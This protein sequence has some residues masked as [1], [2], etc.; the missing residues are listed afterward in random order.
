MKGAVAEAD[1][2]SIACVRRIQPRQSKRPEN[3]GKPE[4]R[5]RHALTHRPSKVA[6]PVCLRRFA[7]SLPAVV[8]IRGG[9]RAVVEGIPSNRRPLGR[10]FR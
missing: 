7:R 1:L 2:F 4:A 8:A 10:T 6:R 9:S 3:R 5:L